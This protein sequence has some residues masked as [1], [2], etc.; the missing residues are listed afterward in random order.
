MQVPRC[1]SVAFSSSLA[2]CHLEPINGL[3]P[4]YFIKAW[5]HLKVP[6]MLVFESV[7]LIGLKRP[8]SRLS[9]R[10]VTFLS[11]SWDSALMWAN[12]GLCSHFIIEPKSKLAFLARGTRRAFSMS[13]KASLLLHPW[14]LPEREC[15][16]A[17]LSNCCKSQA[18]LIFINKGACL[19]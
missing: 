13:S 17:H 6:S 11:C 10:T 7:P 12:G 3:K 19:V 16:Y 5:L 14:H 1:V 9:T 4:V 18:L 15:V 2:P 8:L